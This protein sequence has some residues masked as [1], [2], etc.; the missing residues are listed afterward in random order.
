[1]A[2]STVEKNNSNNSIDLATYIE[3]VIAEYKNY[4]NSFDPQ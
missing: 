1:M 3:Q 4:Q 2:A